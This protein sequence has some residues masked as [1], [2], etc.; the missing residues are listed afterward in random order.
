VKG[1][2]SGSIVSNARLSRKLTWA[3]ERVLVTDFVRYFADRVNVMGNR[4]FSCY[5]IRDR[6]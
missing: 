5:Y 6:K 4:V 1:F 3:E 2:P